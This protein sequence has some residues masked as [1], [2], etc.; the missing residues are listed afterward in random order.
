MAAA[1]A[2]SIV[3]VQVI[4]HAD[5]RGKS[6]YNMT[7]SEERMHSVANFLDGLTLKATALSAKGET[8][9]VLGTNGEDLTLSRRV[10]VLIKTRHVNQYISQN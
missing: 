3:T 1:K 6:G 10:Q 2:E 9:P 8:L 4:G 7:L 5:S